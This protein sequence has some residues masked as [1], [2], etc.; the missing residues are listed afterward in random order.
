MIVRSRWRITVPPLRV[1]RPVA[2][3]AGHSAAARTPEDQHDD[4]TRVTVQEPY[5]Q[6]YGA[7][8]SRIPYEPPIQPSTGKAEP[9]A[10]AEAAASARQSRTTTRHSARWLRNALKTLPADQL[11]ALR[12]HMP[13]T[14]AE[15]LLARL[16][17]RPDKLSRLELHTL[18]HDLVRAGAT[19]LAVW[20]C[21][22]VLEQVQ[23]SSRPRR[24]FAS[25]TLDALG[26]LGVGFE[27]PP[28]P[29][30][31]PLGPIRQPSLEEQRAPEVS[32]FL[33]SLL[34][35]LE[36]LQ[37]VR[38]PRP[39]RLYR[40][41]M[42][43]C[44]N[45][46]RP[47]EAAKIYV[48][49]VEEWIVEG[50]IAEGADPS[51]FYAGGGPPREPKRSSPLLSLWFQGVRTWRLPGEAMSPHDRLDLWHP[52]HRSLHERLRGFPMP[53]PTS[54]PS[55]V[56]HPSLQLLTI[57]FRDLT[58]DP[59]DCSPAEYAAGVRALAMLANTIISRTLPVPA[60]P[61][62]LRAFSNSRMEP[63]VYPESYTYEPK[64]NAWAYTAN[65][66]VHV[67]LVS[68]MFS[69]PNYARAAEIEA[70]F[71]IDKR[72]PGE[73]G[74]GRYRLRPLGWKS[75][76]VLIK[77]AARTL[78]Q[79]R[80]I[81]R[82]LDYMKVT[83][84]EWDASAL[85][86]LFRGSTLSRD[87]DMAAVV[88]DKLFGGSML[89]A[90][91]EVSVKEAATRLQEGSDARPPRKQ[92]QKQP[93]LDGGQRDIVATLLD[94]IDGQSIP[95]D[96]HSLLALVTHLTATSQFDRLVR[97][98]YTLEPYLAVRKDTPLEHVKILAAA[99][100][101]TV[102]SQG[103]ILP[104]EL[105]PHVFTAIVNGL[106]KSGNTGLAQRIFLLAK[107]FEGKKIVA[108]RRA[109]ALQTTDPSKPVTPPPAAARLTLPI[110]M[111]TA[112]IEVFGNE[113]RPRP[114]AIE[115]LPLGWKP[116]AGLERV[117]RAQ[118]GLIMAWEVYMEATSRWRSSAKVVA[119]TQAEFDTS[120]GV[121]P[122][123]YVTHGELKERTPDARFFAAV[124][125]VFYQHWELHTDEQLTRR[126]AA[127]LSRVCRDMKEAGV[128]V[129]PGL[130]TKLATGCVE[131]EI[132]PE[133]V[134]DK[135][136]HAKRR[137]HRDVVR[138]SRMVLRGEQ[139][140]AA[141]GKSHTR[142]RNE[143]GEEAVG[144]IEGRG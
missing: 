142:R 23:A 143:D 61:H 98:V 55:L 53:I 112:V 5:G 103:R 77:Y 44:V 13:R 132:Y 35:L 99:T 104:T 117:P 19:S 39:N 72:I 128:P 107:S 139:V 64:T 36:V 91:S 60:I 68:L 96:A 74:A 95:A 48:G 80:L 54:P 86:V 135:W 33:A 26:K 93:E 137:T 79:P 8:P 46:R 138:P 38:H 85:N 141:R 40:F 16:G 131:G 56:P 105:G 20:L 123:I 66:Q 113:A 31:H 1:V 108:D 45:E 111:Y 10:A 34:H 49:L 51:D 71:S 136:V 52:H 76:I 109:A 58:L 124:I 84:K 119:A 78:H 69:P 14:E 127:Q 133:V 47:D 27:I 70:R 134:N 122:E 28:A 121:E 43:Q 32:E 144:G 90:D 129:P 41:I 67:A 94:D 75:C 11:R 116:T 125:N 92:S 81:S 115:Q 97:L 120:S 30:Q 7:G 126:R 88:E 63:A 106:A 9:V 101:A 114:N 21:V 3:R 59:R 50:R 130:A 24:V 42:T 29:Y 87:N 25:P 17:V 110:H 102:T 89:A 15:G 83:F 12:Q 73:D 18:L 62:M 140:K 82:L 6:A 65:T 57:I 2:H 22:G 118:A 4:G 37:R 100:G